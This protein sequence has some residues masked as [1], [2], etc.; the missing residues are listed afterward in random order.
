MVTSEALSS[1]DV[2]FFMAIGPFWMRYSKFHID[3]ENSGSRSRPKS[4]HSIHSS[5]PK[6][7]PKMKEVQKVVQKLSS[8]QKSVASASIQI[9]T[10]T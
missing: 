5:G 10:N 4:T 2:F 7:K 3:L 9:G 1:I 6:I 8:E